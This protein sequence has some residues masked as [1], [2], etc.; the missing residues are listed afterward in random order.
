M[1]KECKNHASHFFKSQNLR[2]ILGTYT[3]ITNFVS[4]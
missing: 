4:A 2:Q 1:V 3:F